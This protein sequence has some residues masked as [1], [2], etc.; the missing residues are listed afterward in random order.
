LNI[1]A[2]AR[3]EGIKVLIGGTAGDDL[4]SGYRRHQ[5]LFLERYYQYIPVYF[6]KALSSLV[7]EINSHSPFVRRLKKALINAGLSKNERLAGYFM[8]LQEDKVFEL[9]DKSLQTE[10]KNNILP[11]EYWQNLLKSLP[12]ETSDLNKMLFLELNTFLP[13]HNLNYTDKMSMA[14]G[15]E[16]RVPYLD[17][18]LVTFA[19]RLPLKFKMQGKTTKY[20]LRKVAERYLPMD[21]IYRPKTGFGAPV[22]TWIR[23][24]LSIQLANFSKDSI[25]IKKRILNAEAVEKLIADDKAGKVDA[26]YT[27][28]SLLAI[29]SWFNQFLKIK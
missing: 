20:L 27:I 10:L 15:V 13:D 1:C 3:D 6:R 17:L 26:A 4:F 9:F 19:N 12:K 7:G 21:V 22:R 8:W 14:V 23:N 29:D 25:L 16:A 24:D 5:I 11:M 18:E 2:G 28:F